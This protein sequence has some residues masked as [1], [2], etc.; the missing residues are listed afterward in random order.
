MVVGPGMGM[1]PGGIVTR[2]HNGAERQILGP[3]VVQSGQQPAFHLLFR[4]T[5]VNRCQN[6]GQGRFG[7]ADRM[8]QRRD[9]V[10]GLAQTQARDGGLGVGHRDAGPG[11]GQR[12]MDEHPHH[13][14]LDRDGSQR[15]RAGKCGKGIIVAGLIAPV[16][17]LALEADQIE[18]TQFQ[19]RHDGCGRPLGGDRDH[20]RS[21]AGME[22]L[23]QQPLEIRPR[24]QQHR[25]DCQVMGKAAKGRMAV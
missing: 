16:E 14:P 7:N 24:H 22:P 20:Q 17:H 3:M 4:L 10:R 5:D 12:V 23:V 18:R 6:L 2:R 11:P 15:H 21:F 8:F 25:V 19:V 9:L 13:L 1:G